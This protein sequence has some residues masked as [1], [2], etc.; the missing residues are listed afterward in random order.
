MHLIWADLRHGFRLLIR[1]RGFAVTAILTLA[2]GIAA[3]S[4]I[5]SV[6]DSVLLE[7]LPFREPDRLLFVWGRLTGIGLVRDQNGMSPPEFMDLRT[8][9]DVF[10][11]VAAYTS[12]NLNLTGEGDPERIEAAQ[13]S[14]S[15]FPVLGVQP[16]LGRTFTADEDRPGHSK[17][18][19]MSQGLWQRRFASDPGIAGRHLKLDGVDYTVLGVMPAGFELFN[20]AD[21]WTPFAFSADE[22]SENQRGSHYLNIVARLKKSVSMQQ[23][24]AN[25]DALANDLLRQYPQNYT[26]DSG[27]AIRANF[28]ANELTFDTR[29]AMLVLA[30]AVSLL[31][32]I[33]C[34]NVANL[35]LARGTARDREMAVRSAL[36]AG[37]ARLIRQLMTESVLIGLISGIAGLLI[38]GWS[39]LALPKMLPIA[40]PIQIDG[41][42]LAVTFLV[43][44]LTSVLFGVLPAFD[45]SR[46]AESSSR[47]TGG[48]RAR[49]TRGMVVVSEIA[50]ALVLLAGAGLLIKSF[51]KLLSVDAGFRPEGVLTMKVALPDSRYAKSHDAWVFFQRS[52]ENARKIPGVEAAGFISLLPLGSGSSGCIDVESRPSDPSKKC[53]EADR[54]PVTEDYFRAMGIDLVRGRYFG[55]RDE[56]VETPKVAIVDENLA[57]EFWPGE[58]PIGKR[59]MNGHSLSKRPWLEVVG[60]VRHVR[61]RDLSAPSRI[62]IYWPFSQEPWPFGALVVRVRS[63]DPRLLARAAEQAIHQA[64]PELPVYAIRTMNEVIAQSVAQR[65]ITMVLL[66]AFSALAMILAAVGIYG[67]LAYTVAQRT[68]EIG[69]RMAAGARAADVMGLVGREAAK[70][71]FA[72]IAAGIIVSLAAA[73]LAGGLLYGVSP[74]DAGVYSIAALIVGSVALLA[75]L[76]PARRAASVEPMTALRR[77]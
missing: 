50:L 24:Q 35:L 60:V 20:H 5:F 51:F 10:E 17:V 14:A 28:L 36:G 64:D 41:R 69:I 27:W 22:L 8:R 76:A 9:A 74:A 19:V 18:V 40:T 45:A 48:E 68:R 47:V 32:W 26:A 56:A 57:A 55:A 23:A 21:F 13:V 16:A 66:I 1:N 77:E 49:R 34:A 4:V 37:R 11:D 39:A 6:V 12:S 30:G 29:P 67:V 73:K 2:L 53:P 61:N 43:A 54:R 38:A 71:A 62:Q 72:G 52:T 25:L 15:F 46:H 58:D 3:T 70:F 59:I 33:A 7:P 75:S 65:K 63:G 44:M 42:M 31:L